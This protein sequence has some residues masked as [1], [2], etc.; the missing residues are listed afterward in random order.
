MNE[1][2]LPVDG[3]LVYNGD[4]RMTDG[5]EAAKCFMQLINPPDAIMAATDL[6]AIGALNYLNEQ[7]I[8]VPGQ[9]AVV[10]LPTPPFW[11]ATAITFPM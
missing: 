7:E 8:L 9:V 6:M 2:G 5:M 10:V 11:F 1:A 3:S 4:F